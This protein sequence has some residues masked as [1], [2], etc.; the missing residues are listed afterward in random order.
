MSYCVKSVFLEKCIILWYNYYNIMKE[1]DFLEL[2][3]F[4]L[5][6]LD[7]RMKVPVMYGPFHLTFFALSVSFGVYLYKKHK[8]PD[9]CYVNKLL[10]VSAVIVIVLE[11]LKQINFTFTYDGNKI[12]ADYQW[13]AFPFQFCST[14]MYVSLIACFLKKGNTYRGLCSYLA[15]FSVFAGFVVMLYPPQVYIDVAFINVQTMVCHGLMIS[16][17]IYLLSSGYVKLE[18][19]TMIGACSVFAVLVGVA[20]I[21]NELVYYSGIL[22]DES[23]NMFF[24]SPHFPP[25]LPVYSTVQAL[26]PFPWCMVIYILVFSLAAYLILLLAMAVRYILRK[27]HNTDNTDILAS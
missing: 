2:L 6:I 7:T 13:Y 1:G 21:M 8:N 15:T 3:G 14:P 9:D 18:H 20:A 11:I 10:F 4:L 23:F 16:V 24:I 12:N 5:K 22:G 26:V 19:K 25:S 17:G 27:F